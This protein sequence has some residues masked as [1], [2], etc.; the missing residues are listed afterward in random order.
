MHSKG[1][2]AVALA[3]AVFALS[4][5]SLLN[6]F[7]LS[8][9]AADFRKS[10]IDKMI[11]LLSD[12]D[13]YQRKHG[14]YLLST[15]GALA[16][17]AVPKLIELLK[18]PVAQGE[19][20]SALGKVG[21]EAKDAVSGLIVFLQDKQAGYDRV[22]AAD[23]LGLIA[24]EPD[25]VVPVLMNVMQDDI[26]P[27]TRRSAAAALGHFGANAKVAVPFLIKAINE[28]DKDMREDAALSLGQIGGAP[29]DIAAI[30]ELLSD[31][32]DIAR[33]GAA[34]ALGKIGGEAASAVPDLVKLLKDRS[35]NVR[36][37]AAQ[38]L[39]EIGPDAKDAVEALKITQ[40]SD[41]SAMVSA[42]AQGS[43]DLITSKRKPNTQ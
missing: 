15:T 6:S 37:A 2:R 39:G 28:G 1:R 5:T 12:P 10:D 7:N 4:S 22:Y 34:H 8:A 24:Q 33:Y 36:C 29:K 14:A 30:V 38:A 16:K 32:I 20:A 3:W 18:D 13:P 40:K 43:L 17:P 21:A 19:A 23:A 9:S 31:E 26:E 11:D 35:E 25:K 41:E 42:Q 27:V